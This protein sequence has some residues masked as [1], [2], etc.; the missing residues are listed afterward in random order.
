VD[1]RG[2]GK[3]KDFIEGTGIVLDNSKGKTAVKNFRTYNESVTTSKS[4]GAEVGE[5]EK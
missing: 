4:G 5:H 1:R 3:K 2:N